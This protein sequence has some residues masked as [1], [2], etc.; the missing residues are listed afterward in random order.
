M[1]IITVRVIDIWCRFMISWSSRSRSDIG[2]S[3]ITSPHGPSVWE[4]SSSAGEDV[5]ASSN[6]VFG[7]GKLLAVENKC[8]SI[9]AKACFARSALLLQSLESVPLV[10]NLL[11]IVVNTTVILFDAVVVAINFVVVVIN[12]VFKMIDLIVQIDECLSDSF[13]GNHQLCLGLDSFF[14]V[15]LVPDYVPLVEVRDL[16]PEV[17]S[18]NITVVLRCIILGFIAM[19]RSFA[20][21]GWLIVV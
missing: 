6:H 7:P 19:V 18:W 8:I 12:T 4:L 13:K 20:S 5:S 9:L 11:V 1:S 3:S 16:I 21:W 10:I 2:R 15:Y 14:V 17:S